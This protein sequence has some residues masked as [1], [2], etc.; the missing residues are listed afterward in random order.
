MIPSLYN[1]SISTSACSAASIPLPDLFGAE[2]L[3]LEATLTSNYSQYIGTGYYTNHGP[4]NITDVSFCNVT[5]SYTH[6]GQNDTVTVQV[7]L[8]TDTWNGRLQAIGG[9]GWQA[10]LYLPSLMGM[11]AAVGEGYS[12][13]STDAGLGSDVFPTNWGLLSSGNVNLFLLQNLA[14]V[15]LNDAAI[16]AKSIT[17][18]FYGE[19]PKYSYFSGCSQGGRQGLMLAQRYPDAFDGIVASAPAINWNDFVVGDFWPSYIMDTVGE[20][21]PACEI[22]AITSAALAACDADDGLKD[23]ILSN[24]ASCIFN[25]IELV[26]TTINCTTLGTTR[27]ISSAAATIVQETWSGA[28]RPDNSS[29]WYGPYMGS[30][31]TGS[32]TDP[33]LLSTICSLNGTCTAG[34][35]EIAEDWI[36]IFLKKD[37]GADVRGLTHEQFDKFAEMSTQQFD[38]IIGTN[39]PDL[40]GFRNRGGKMITYHGMADTIIPTRGTEH[41]YDAVMALDPN[42]HDFYRVFLAPGLGHCFGGAGP[43]PDTAFDAMRA[44]VE[45]GVA[46]ETLVATSVGST[47]FIQRPLSSDLMSWP[48]ALLLQELAV[49]REK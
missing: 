44:W 48:I 23:G 8:P 12:T 14:S 33:A 47:S 13:V 35:F 46:P 36:K 28:K 10:G 42:V 22:D 17:T 2:F 31:L 5:L 45:T 16:I 38:S 21:P 1:G 41:Y 7:L 4:V 11:K 49:S 39:D 9:G 3:S 24:P 15:S 27:T 30:A 40:S 20:Y 25:A 34:S 29:I 19:A 26:G 43:Y 37:S 6:P 32:I 18:S